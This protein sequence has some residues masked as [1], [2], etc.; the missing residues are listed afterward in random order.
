MATA[1][2]ASVTVSIG[3]D[4][5]GICS[6]ML[7]VTLVVSDTFCWGGGRRWLCCVLMRFAVM[8]WVV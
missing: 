3:D 5:M 8:L 4:T 6:S 1:I 7:R 2:S